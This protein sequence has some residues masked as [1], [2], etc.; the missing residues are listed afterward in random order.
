MIDRETRCEFVNLA[1]VMNKEYRQNRPKYDY[2]YLKHASKGGLLGSRDRYAPINFEEIKNKLR[3]PN[4]EIEQSFDVE[5]IKTF[6][7]KGD[8]PSSAYRAPEPSQMIPRMLYYMAK[9]CFPQRRRT[10]LYPTDDASAPGKYIRLRRWRYDTQ[11]CGHLFSW[12]LELQLFRRLFAFWR[13]IW[14]C[15]S[16][17][18][19]RAMLRGLRLRKP[20][21][22]P[23]V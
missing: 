19:T 3:A 1:I 18:F 7:Q 9:M 4:S 8:R 16:T 22:E 14:N 20:F 10:R 12:I 23:C 15:S 13:G 2:L 17:K 6:V 11:R 5:R 21:R